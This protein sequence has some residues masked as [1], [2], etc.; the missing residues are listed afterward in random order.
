MPMNPVPSQ[1]PM[2]VP[3]IAVPVPLP[4]CTQPA[5]DAVVRRLD[6]LF[7]NAPTTEPMQQLRRIVQRYRL[8]TQA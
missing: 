6:W 4:Q 2:A 1:V 7:R 5:A 8:E 3:A